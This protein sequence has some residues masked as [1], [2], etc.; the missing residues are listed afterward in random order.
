MFQLRIEH[1]VPDYDAW[2]QM[3]DSDPAGREAM[4]VRRYRILRATGDPNQVMIDLE[5][6]SAD[7]ADAMLAA[8]QGIWGQVQGTLIEG[9]SARVADVVESVEL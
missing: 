9:P 4:G 7:Q 1:S 5:F 8:L 3:F 6:D 2:K